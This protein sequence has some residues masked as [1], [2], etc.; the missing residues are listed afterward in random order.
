MELELEGQ[1]RGLKG[2]RA[3]GNQ[4]GGLEGYLRGLEGHLKGL[5][6]PRGDRE[7]QTQEC[8]VWFHRSLAP[9][10]ATA[11]KRSIMLIHVLNEPFGLF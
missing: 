4:M 3:L 8:P 5:G 2:L 7:T 1:L 9:T 6:A 11:Q 10:E